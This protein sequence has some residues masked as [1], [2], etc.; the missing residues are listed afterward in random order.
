MCKQLLDCRCTRR[1]VA[2]PRCNPILW[3]RPRVSP[4]DRRYQ[5]PGMHQP[6]ERRFDLAFVI[7]LI[8]A[9]LVVLDLHGGHGMR[10]LRDLA[11][12]LIFVALA[13]KARG[14]T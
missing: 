8:V 6:R 2:E 5:G 9:A 12:G 14:T 10:A 7:A 11:L 4:G 1:A 13:L 3:D